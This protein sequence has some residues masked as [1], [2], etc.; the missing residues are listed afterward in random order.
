M[1]DLKVQAEN[2][3]EF[4]K[5]ASRRLRTRG[6]IPGVL[7]GQGMDPVALSVDPKEI[8]RILSSETGR[9]TIFKLEVGADAKNVLIR[10]YQLDP[11]KGTLIHADFQAIA[12]DEVRVFEVPIEMVGVP[13]GVKEGGGIVDFVLRQVEVQCLPADVPDHIRV[14]VEAL[15]IG[16]AVRVEN[17]RVDASKVEILS[18]PELVIITIVLPYVEKEPEVILEEASA[19]PEVIRK[20]RGEEEESE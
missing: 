8:V 2:R 14:D 3:Q 1:Q 4:G 11:I 17:L 9:N 6:K 7:Y 20:G 12:M 15:E 19:E 18:D 5:N 13:K 16:D 10:D